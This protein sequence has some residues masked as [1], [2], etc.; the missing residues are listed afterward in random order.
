MTSSAINTVQLKGNLTHADRAHANYWSK[1]M[2]IL[3]HT[4]M[5]GKKN[6][7]ILLFKRQEHGLRGNTVGLYVATY[8]PFIDYVQYILLYIHSH[9][10]SFLC[11]IL[12]ATG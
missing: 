4:G 6:L 7:P 9:L 12:C 3:T 2:V 10:A 5:C 8:F 11:S 1:H